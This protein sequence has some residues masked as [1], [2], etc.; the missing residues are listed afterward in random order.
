MDTTYT[1]RHA[2]EDWKHYAVDQSGY[3]SDENPYSAKAII[4]TLQEVRS[5]EVIAALNIGREITE[6]MVQTLPCVEVEEMDRNECPC[7]PASGCYWMKTKI[8]IPKYIRA[9]SVTG[10]VANGDN[11]RFSFIKWDRF[12]YIPESRNLTMRN[13]MYWSIRD[14]NEGPY[15]YLYGNRFIE[16]ISISAIWEDP[17]EVAAFPSCGEVN[18]EAYCNPLDVNFHT[19]AWLRDIIISKA[20]Q[21]LL[22]VRQAAILDAQ[23]DDMPGNTGR[24]TK[25]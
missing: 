15:L 10:I 6:F 24:R 17:M 1:H 4:R 9:I 7:A 13:G 11:P 19:D 8:A 5:G 20:W 12:Q 18:M 16:T 22:S 21:K 14:T 23:N 25:A 2:L 3:V